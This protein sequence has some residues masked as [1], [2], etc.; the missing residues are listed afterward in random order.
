M[1]RRPAT[2]DLDQREQQMTPVE[3]TIYP[4]GAGAFACGSPDGHQLRD[5]QPIEVFLG[6]RWI[7]GGIAHHAHQYPQFIALDDQSICGLC[8]GMHVR[9][10]QKKFVYGNE[11]GA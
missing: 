9:L 4:T 1:G 11:K 2:L 8:A 7:A 10:P 3:W 5:G 6:G